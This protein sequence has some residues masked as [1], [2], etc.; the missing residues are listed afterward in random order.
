MPDSVVV[1]TADG[2]TLVRSAAV[3]HIGERL[4]G[5]WRPARP[6]CESAAPLVSRR[7]VRWH[8]P[9]APVLRR[10]RRSP[11]AACPI[12]A[13]RTAA[14]ALPL[15]TSS[16]TTRQPFPSRPVSSRKSAVSR[17]VIGPTA[18]SPITRPSIFVTAASSPIVPVQKASS[19]R[20][21]S[22]RERSHDLMG[23]A[24]LR[25]ELEHRRPGDPFGAGDRSGWCAR[26]R[27]PRRT[28]GSRWFRPRSR[29]CPA[30]GRHRRRRRWPR[31][32]PGSTEAGCSDG[33]WGRGSRGRIGAPSW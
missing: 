21:A 28:G 13:G 33:S 11:T 32:W 5:T 19:A 9:G 29:G 8:C 27:A 30:S 25:Q 3:I 15:R 20:Y 6:Q 12:L 2:R 23:D 26:R 16:S 10:V 24:M 17:C 31:S 7:G 22:V 18:P 1:R 4:G 14:R